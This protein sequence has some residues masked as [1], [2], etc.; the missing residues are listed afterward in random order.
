MDFPFL[1]STL[2]RI[3]A[4]LPLTLE[5][6]LISVTAGGVLAVVMAVIG[7]RSVVASYAIRTFTLLFRG[8][9]LLIQ[10]FIIYYGLGQFRWIRASWAWVYLREPFWCALLALTLCT[11]AYASEI[12]RG[13]LQ[14]VPR[15]AIEAGRV[16]GMSPALLLR[17][18][19]LPIAIRHA[20][21]AYGNEIIIIFKASSLASVVTLL[22]MTGIAYQIMSETF[23]PI[24]VFLCAGLLYIAVT[25]ALSGA[26]AAIERRLNPHLRLA[27]AA[28][29]MPTIG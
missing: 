7:A 15:G 12:F 22:D 18:I 10:I 2:W 27:T 28:S 8:S 21:P 11:A 29:P 17:R 20:L 26:L 13:A 5:L 9:P 1:A 14:S 4:G 3:L 16:T 19:V 6:T 23:R 24:A 25:L